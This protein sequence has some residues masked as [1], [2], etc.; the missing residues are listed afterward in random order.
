MLRSN[1]ASFMKGGREDTGDYFLLGS[2]V[3]YIWRDAK[4]AR[5]AKNAYYFGS[6][7]LNRGEELEECVFIMLGLGGFR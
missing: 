5:D 3:Y 6:R 2:K 4:D 1:I 7:I